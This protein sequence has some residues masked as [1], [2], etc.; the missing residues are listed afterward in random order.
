[1]LSFILTL[2]LIFNLIWF[3]KS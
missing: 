1:M 2:L 3:P